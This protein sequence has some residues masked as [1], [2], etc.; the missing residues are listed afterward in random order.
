MKITTERMTAALKALSAVEEG[1]S[2]LTFVHHCLKDHGQDQMVEFK[3][4]DP[5]R[6]VSVCAACL[7]ELVN[8]G[9]A[10]DGMVTVRMIREDA[11]AVEA[12]LKYREQLTLVPMT[13]RIRTAL[14]AYVPLDERALAR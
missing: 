6:W 12:A 7:A 14:G 5:F 8:E 13:E 3:A 9:V 4:T 1:R 11:A 10:D 2:A